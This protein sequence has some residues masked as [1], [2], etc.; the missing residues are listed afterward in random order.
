[1]ENGDIIP[2]SF[3]CCCSMMMRYTHTQLMT[4]TRKGTCCKMFD[5][6]E[7]RN[8]IYPFFFFAHRCIGKHKKI[9]FEGS[10]VIFHAMSILL[11]CKVK[12]TMYVCHDVQF[13][14]CYV[15]GSMRFN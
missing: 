13:I 6:Q 10:V 9:S 1:M 8:V 14:R 2:S 15:S 7:F 11:L 5:L 12:C 3:C 4:L